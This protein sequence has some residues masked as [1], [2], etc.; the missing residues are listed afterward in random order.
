MTTSIRLLD[1]AKLVYQ[2]IGVLSIEIAVFYIVKLIK[3]RDA[4]YEASPDN[5]YFLES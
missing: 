3:K 1:I 2:S 5:Q 4:S